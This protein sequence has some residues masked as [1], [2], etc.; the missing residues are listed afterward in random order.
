MN[1]RQD[2][3]SQRRLELLVFTAILLTTIYMWHKNLPKAYRENDETKRAA[4]N[5]LEIPTDL[6]NNYNITN[7]HRSNNF[8]YSLSN[9]NFSP[10][11]K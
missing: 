8:N 9:E 10:Y 2:P 3:I 5:Q 1:T 11:S 6:S 4:P 7:S